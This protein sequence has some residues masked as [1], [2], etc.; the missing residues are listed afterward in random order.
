MDQWSKCWTLGIEIHFGNLAVLSCCVLGQNS[1]L[2][3][4]LSPY[5]SINGYSQ[6]ARNT[7]QNLRGRGG[8][9]NRLASYT[10]GSDNTPNSFKLLKPGRASARGSIGNDC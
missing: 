10:G 9:F 2:L 4:C 5:R 3:Q 8:T 1:Y 7:R 6:T